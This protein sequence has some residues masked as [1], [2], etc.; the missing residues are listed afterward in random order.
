MYKLF[1]SL[2]LLALAACG[3][4]GGPQTLGGIAAPAAPSGSETK[5]VNGGTGAGV[6]A[7]S[8][9]SGSTAVAPSFLNSSGERT[10]NAIGAGSSYTID[11]GELYQGNA[12]T[13]TTPL[14]TI[15]YNPRDGIFSI[16]LADD[17]SGINRNIRTQDPAHRTDFNPAWTPQPGVPDLAGFNYLE[18]AEDR[19]AATFFYQRPGA[20][21][22]YVT[23][24]GFVFN[25][26]PPNG[27]ERY[28]RAAMVLG[29]QTSVFQVPTKG[30]MTYNGGFIA[31]MIN[32]PTLDNA[33][34]KASTYQWVY[35]SS[36]INVDFGKQ[37]FALS[38]NGKVDSSATG[39]VTITSG[40]TF[41]ASGSGKVDMGRFGGFQGAF[42]SACFAAACG[43]AGAVPI[44]FSAISTGSSTAGASS[45]DGTFYG[46]NAVN[47]GGSFRIIG[48][49]PD[50]RVDMNGAFTGAKI[51]N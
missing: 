1:S 51:G 10:Y 49:I 23:L 5:D 11:E 37:T 27:P 6:T 20:A 45:I 18:V 7:G 4:G 43:S 30:S 42:Q 19:G 25:S 22:V 50:Q 44:D 40:T 41:A 12:S 38:L 48:G 13:A 28:E 31:S 17:K 36:I 3:G 24:A 9:G 8:G 14:G 47:V 15:N 26:V 21:T 29:E 46:P 39:P 16:K 33:K 2:P 32:N 34:P 35:G